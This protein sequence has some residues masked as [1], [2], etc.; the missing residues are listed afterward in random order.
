MPGQQSLVLPLHLHLSCPYIRS[1]FGPN[2]LIIVEPDCRIDLAIGPCQMPWHGS[3]FRDQL[4]AARKTKALRTKL[5][6]TWVK[7]LK[8]LK[9]LAEKGSVPW[10]KDQRQGDQL[11]RWIADHE[12][13]RV[14]GGSCH[15][16]VQ[17]RLSRAMEA[18][19]PT[20]LA[21]Y[22]IPVLVHQLPNWW[23][24]SGSCDDRR[25]SFQK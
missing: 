18:G 25:V 14:L 2:H 5:P 3:S 11:M 24:L 22:N 19:Q 21:L 13:L 17:S 16:P 6:Q 8:S 9:S 4:A 12:Q 20:S 15:R 23:C 1:S 10:I 7:S